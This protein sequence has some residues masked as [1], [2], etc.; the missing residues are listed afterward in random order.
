M[1]E[2]YYFKWYMI[3]KSWQELFDYFWVSNFLKNCNSPLKLI[4]TD[5]WKVF[6]T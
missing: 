1:E 2:M 6:D 4:E 3:L 5:Q